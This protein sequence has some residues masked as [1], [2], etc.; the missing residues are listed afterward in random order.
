MRNLFRQVI[1]VV[2]FQQDNS[3]YLGS[4]WLK[5]RMQPNNMSASWVRDVFRFLNYKILIYFCLIVIFVQFFTGYT[6][7]KYS[8]S[9]SVNKKLPASDETLQLQELYF[10][11]EEAYKNSSR[12]SN[13][14]L[15]SP[16]KSSLVWNPDIIRKS[17]RV[18]YTGY[19]LYC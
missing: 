17:V 18:P 3:L 19:L 4:L 9:D 14:E 16:V 5:I 6:L 13:V 11:R 1:G 2:C 8:E 12:S 7:Y 15:H 10:I